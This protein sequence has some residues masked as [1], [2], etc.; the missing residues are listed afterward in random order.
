MATISGLRQ[1]PIALV[2]D[3][4]GLLW[5]ARDFHWILF[6][7][8]HSW[9]MR[10]HWVLVQIL[11]YFCLRSVHLLLR[12]GLT[13]C[14]TYRPLPLLIILN[15]VTVRQEEVRYSSWD[16]CSA[17]CRF[18]LGRL[19]RRASPGHVDLLSPWTLWRHTRWSADVRCMGLKQ[20]VLEFLDDSSAPHL[21]WTFTWTSTFLIK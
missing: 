19:Q 10:W 12:S 21:Y 8:C 9:T 15:S 18:E 17:W 11:C 20:H 4:P 14:L 13:F 5:V 3:S 2:C 16:S 7:F 1:D 6:V